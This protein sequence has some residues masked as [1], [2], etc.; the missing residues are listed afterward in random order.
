MAG[1]GISITL[2]VMFVCCLMFTAALIKNWYQV[3]HRWLPLSGL[4]IMSLL[5]GVLSFVNMADVYKRQADGC[6]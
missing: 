1:G 6:H 4:G 5:L 2:D 3:K